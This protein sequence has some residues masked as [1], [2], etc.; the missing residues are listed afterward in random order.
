MICMSTGRSLYRIHDKNPKLGCHP[1]KD[2]HEAN[3]WNEQGWGIFWTVNQFAGPRVKENCTKI[4]SWCVD[5]DYGSIDAQ[6]MIM[7][8]LPLDPS[9]IIRTRR[10]HHLYFD[11][12][13]GTSMGCY[14]DVVERLIEAFNGDANA[15]DICRILRVPTY[16]HWKEVDPFAVQLTYSSNSVYTEK[17]MLTAFPSKKKEEEIEQRTALKKE[18][19]FHS[20]QSLWEKIWS[21]D[22]EQ[23]LMRLS[24]TPSVGGERYSFKR[25]TNGNLN[26]YV[27]GK[28]TSC[29]ID[30]NKRI[31]SSSGGGPTVY[32]WLKWFHHDYKRTLEIMREHFPEVFK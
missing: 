25:N 31:G 17:D 8:A 24:G 4:I 32:Q 10:G 6:R 29:F 15:K 16:L 28:G 21:M 11:A 30:T 13:E 23:A 18:L 26:I 3:H 7:Q 5:I 27:D 19:K 22:C 14:R 2:F 9:A 20:N 12:A 1:V